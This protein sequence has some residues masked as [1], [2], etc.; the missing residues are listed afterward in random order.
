MLAGVISEATHAFWLRC[1]WHSF[2]TSIATI[3]T[4][5]MEREKRKCPT[6]YSF[7]IFIIKSELEERA[8]YL[9][10]PL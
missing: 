5:K 9:S 4:A 2:S 7:E 1:E 6:P 8:I 10:I 3:A